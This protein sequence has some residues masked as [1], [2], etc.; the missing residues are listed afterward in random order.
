M[1]GFSAAWLAL[2]EP[3]DV[4]A[5]A[6]D[7]AESFLATIAPDGLVV[8]LGA[9]AG[10]NIAWLNGVRGALRWRHV[11]AD[12]R[13]IAV[14]RARFAGMARVSFAEIDLAR[15]LGRALDGVS[16]VTCAALLD[17]ASAGWAAEL[18]RA[19]ATRRLPALIALTYDGR[20]RWDPPHR[21]DD[22]VIAAFHRDMRRD[23]GFGPALGPDATKFMMDRLDAAGARLA[24][25]SSD[26]R[27]AR[28]DHALLQEMIAG[29]AG[30]S[31]AGAPED[32]ARIAAWTAERR[33]QLD[34]RSLTLEIGHQDLLA[35]WA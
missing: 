16:A 26:W 30:A 9:G 5:R 3:F 10:S 1:T 6:R 25:R 22:R 18:A 12:P 15:D 31:I 13:L 17:L 20:M 24:T 8:D 29:I 35:R 33:A 34:Q 14:A 32:A 21:D 7:L 19:L 23:K 11:D 27:V 4:A 28:T 2:R